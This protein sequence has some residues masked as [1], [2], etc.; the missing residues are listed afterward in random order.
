MDSIRVFFGPDKK[1]QAILCRIIL[2]VILIRLVTL[3]S[4]PLMDTTESRYA[5]IAREM[6]VTGNWVTPQL[7]PGQSFW[8]KPPLSFWLTAICFKI[9]GINEF[10]ARF[11]SFIF[12]FLSGWLLF[13]LA[14]KLYGRNFA[15]FST[16]VLATTGLFF[17]LSGS[18]MTDAALTF[19]VTLSLVSFFLTVHERRKDL[20]R[21]WGYGF[22]AGLGMGL[23]A[24]GPIACLLVFIPVFGWSFLNKEWKSLACLP[25]LTG[26]LLTAI[27]AAPWY[28]LAESKTPGF[29]NYFFIGEHFKRFF[30]KGWSG[31]L[32]GKAHPQP[33]GMIWIFLIPATLPWLVVFLSIV[34]SWL[35][36]KKYFKKII[37]EKTVSYF[38]LW[39]LAPLVLFTFSGNILLTYVMPA[40]P[41][42]AFLTSYF[43]KK[44][45]EDFTL[46]P[47]PW[48]FS[49]KKIAAVT[50]FV[51]A[52]FL[53]ASFTF[54]PSLAN[55]ESQRELIS[56]F[57]KLDTAGRATLVYTR[58]MP[59]SAQFYGRKK[60]LDMPERSIDQIL[61][62]LYDK[63]ADFFAIRQD[64]LES[65]MAVGS[66]FTDET[67]RF[68]SY[69]L[70]R[71][72]QRQ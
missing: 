43:L 27:I 60:V 11:S 17:V 66:Q 18:V 39:F 70:R 20:K 3:G 46:K 31:D 33:K 55:K 58:P 61:T 22:F 35:K 12:S 19:S 48:F 16:V 45:L 7:E 34:F 68:G 9:F 32:Y 56:A 54:L 24:K 37:S 38:L 44:S 62:K 14:D 63:N 21:L 4:Y 49:M 40:L 1:Y 52:C 53:I 59:F 42:F 71:E 25:W 41:A 51:P 36:E 26:I 50:A 47:A 67:G 15:L 64:D 2:G 23:L 10:A 72:F 30:V 57:L 8:A 5:E 6:V 13:I 69:I 28:L 65:F 29:L